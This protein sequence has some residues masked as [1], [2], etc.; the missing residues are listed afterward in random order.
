MSKPIKW[1]KLSSRRT[2]QTTENNSQE[3][4]ACLFSRKRRS[5]GHE[6]ELRE[7]LLQSPRIGIENCPS[8]KAF[9]AHLSNSHSSTF[10]DLTNCFSRKH[11]TLSHARFEEKGRDRKN[12]KAAFT[13]ARMKFLLNFQT[14]KT[15]QARTIVESFLLSARL[16]VRQPSLLHDTVHAIISVIH[17][18]VYDK[19]QREG[20]KK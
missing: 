4:A 18:K 11:A 9:A 15:T 10:S 14:Q 16:Q 17:E 19:V 12:K 13:V 7:E 5:K 1:I 2:D 3:M 20:S 8:R 6:R